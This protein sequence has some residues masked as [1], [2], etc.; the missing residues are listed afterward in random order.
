M[1]TTLPS[2]SRLRVQALINLP[3]I[4]AYLPEATNKPAIHFGST[5]LVVN[6]Q[7]KIIIII[8]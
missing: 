4:N 7:L 2:M 6:Y 1:M 8:L 5:T 3:Q